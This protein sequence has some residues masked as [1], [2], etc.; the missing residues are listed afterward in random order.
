MRTLGWS[1]PLTLPGEVRLSSAMASA[2]LASRASASA[3]ACASAF[4]RAAASSASAAA[5]SASVASGGEGSCLIVSIYH[6][7][8]LVH[9]GWLDYLEEVERL[10][11][12]T[13]MP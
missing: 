2:T 12:C 1:S 4:A 6:L 9:N 7:R 3:R 8:A 13:F 11:R 10:E 5:S